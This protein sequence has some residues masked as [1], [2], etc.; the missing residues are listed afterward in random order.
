MLV[1]VPSLFVTKVKPIYIKLTCVSKNKFPFQ[2]M[3][4]T[5]QNLFSLL[6]NKLI[7]NIVDN[8]AF[9]DGLN[10]SHCNRHLYKAIGQL[11]KYWQRTIDEVAHFSRK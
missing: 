4:P 2:K 11:S 6:P 3:S 1:L 7:E 10:L 8:L 9:K 5:E